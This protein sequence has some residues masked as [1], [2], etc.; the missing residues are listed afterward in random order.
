MSTERAPSSGATIRTR[1]GLSP[2]ERVRVEQLAFDYGEAA[3]SYLIVEPDEQLIVLPDF[4]GVAAIVENGCPGCLNVPGGMLAPTFDQ[5]LELLLD[6]RNRVGP[7]C[8][9]VNIYSVLDKDIPLMEKAGYQ[10]NKFG[11]EPVLDLGDIDWKGKPFEWIRR[12]SNFCERHNVECVEVHRDQLPT[13]EWEHIK[14]EMTRVLTEDLKDRPY[15]RELLL[16]EGRLM[17]EYLGRRRLFIARQKGRPGLEAYLVCNP[18]CGGRRWG[19]ESYRRSGDAT[20]G[21]MAHLMRTTIDLLQAEGVEQ[22]DL[23]VV[24]GAGMRRKTHPS[25]SWMVQRGLDLWYRRLDMFMGFR[26]QEYFKSRFRPRMVNRFVGAYPKASIRSIL[27][28]FRTA[29]AFS[30]SYRNVAR[31]AWQQFRNKFRRGD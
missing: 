14:S 2:A 9:T 30:P 25:E 3:E 26:G 10:I 15:P 24:P 17:P 13:D 31:T 22:V 19:F 12:Q 29:G 23:C 6:L 27:S 21:V 18:M 11:E 4:A 28:F 1:A 5:K 7:G 16:L 8:H 20:R